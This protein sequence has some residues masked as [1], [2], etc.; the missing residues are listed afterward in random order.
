[1]SRGRSGKPRRAAPKASRQAPRRALVLVFGESQHDRGA[2]VELTTGLRPDFAGHIEARRTPLV[3][4]KKASLETARSNATDIAKLVRQEAAARDVVAVLAHEDCD[5]LEPAHVAAAAKIERALEEAGCPSTPIAVTPAWELEAW[6][7]VF[8][9][10]VAAVTTGWRTPSGW[11][12]RDIGQLANAKEELTRAVRSPKAKAN[13]RAYHEADSIEIAQGIVKQ[14]LL[15]SFDG[16]YRQTPGKG[17]A[18]AR[19]KS[20]SF[21][22]FRRKVLA[23]PS[24]QPR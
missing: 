4:I 17:V 8:P 10:A 20:A 5:A 24:H 19:T 2:I 15:D 1:M 6:W 9:E 11:I 7:L 3:L 23:L 16:D 21:G 18:V 14:R 12:G 13:A 22:A